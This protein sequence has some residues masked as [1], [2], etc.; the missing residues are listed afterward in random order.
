MSDDIKLYIAR[1]RECELSNHHLAIVNKLSLLISVRVGDHLLLGF[2][3][4]EITEL[5]DELAIT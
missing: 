5:I 2:R 3:S 4:P 1:T